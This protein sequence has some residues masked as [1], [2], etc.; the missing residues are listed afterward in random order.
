[1]PTIKCVFLMFWCLDVGLN[2]VLRVSNYIKWIISDHFSF[3][4]NDTGMKIHFK[5]IEANKS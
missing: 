2:V 3:N 5:L 4:L 1:M